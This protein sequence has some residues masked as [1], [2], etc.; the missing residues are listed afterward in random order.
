VSKPAPQFAWV[1]GGTTCGGTTCG[2]TTLWWPNPNRGATTPAVAA[3]RR[4]SATPTRRY[5]DPATEPGGPQD[6]IETGARPAAARSAS[7]AN[8]RDSIARREREG[9]AVHQARAT[10]DPAEVREGP[11]VK[12]P[13]DHLHAD[14]GQEIVRQR[15]DRHDPE[16]RPDQRDTL[17]HHR[18]RSRRSCERLRGAPRPFP[19]PSLPSPRS[20]PLP[21]PSTGSVRRH[22]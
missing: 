11:F 5:A 14:R 2:G 20:R 10:A 17:D 4:P 12:R 3:P 6:A 7:Y 1:V 15:S 16:A 22:C 19:H 9:H 8:A 21:R 18:S 13:I